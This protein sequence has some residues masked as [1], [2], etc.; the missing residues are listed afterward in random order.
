MDLEA[1]HVLAADV[2]HAGDFRA[3]LVGRPVM[4]EGLHFPRVGV[5]GRLH[6]VLPVA[7]GEAA[8]D[9]GSLRHGVVQAG[10]FFDDDLQGR[11]LV[12]AV[13][14]VQNFLVA[15]DGHDLGG[16]GTGVDA[17][18]DRTLI[19]SQVPPLH[20]VLVVAFQESLVFLGAA[21]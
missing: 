14:R 1:L 6:D 16:G 10:E 12:A 21:E 19:G 3:E 11:A 5:H 9:P 2:Q 15:A 17:H 20:F 13:I 8:G 4:G 18:V 7:G